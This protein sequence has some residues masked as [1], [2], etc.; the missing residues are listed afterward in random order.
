MS[1]DKLRL[2][3]VRPS[4]DPEKKYDAR[5]E[6]NGREKIVRFGAR[7]MSDYT[8]NKDPE[9]RR[10]YIERH[11]ARENFNKPDTPGA[12]SRHLLWGESTSLVRNLAAF[13][14]KFNL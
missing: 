6:R 11:S 7:G 2:L 5:F 8:K 4:S 14:R 1:T 3:S 13:R 12:L 10:R 9:R